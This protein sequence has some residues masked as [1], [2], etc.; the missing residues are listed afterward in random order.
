MDATEEQ[1]HA[2]VNGQDDPVLDPNT[3]QSLRDLAQAMDVT[4]FTQ[5]LE[6]FLADGA[7]RIVALQRAV[8]AEDALALRQEAHAL[9]GA[10]MNVGASGLQ[11][12]CQRC[13]DLGQQQTVAGALPLL[14]LLGQE[15]SRVQQA[16]ARELATP[17]PRSQS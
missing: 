7:E 2:E 3:L 1:Q 17:I 9:K 12:L 6:I 11:A 10:S 13:E 15:F 16:V 4:L 5:V 8:A 14:T